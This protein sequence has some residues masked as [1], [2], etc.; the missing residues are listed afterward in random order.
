MEMTLP[1]Y[2]AAIEDAV[3]T[4]SRDRNTM[5]L[6]SDRILSGTKPHAFGKG[7]WVTSRQ[8]RHTNVRH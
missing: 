1:P 5:Y 6:K 8:A 2:L 4:A 3:R 7:R